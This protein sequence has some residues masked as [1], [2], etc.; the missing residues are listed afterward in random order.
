MPRPR[1]VLDVPVE[2]VAAGFHECF[3]RLCRVQV[4][5][6]AEDRR[7][8]ADRQQRRCGKPQGAADMLR[9]AEQRRNARRR[10]VFH[11]RAADERVHAHADD[12]RDD[13]LTA[14]KEQPRND[15]DCKIA[16]ASMQKPEHR[17]PVSC[18]LLLLLQFLSSLPWESKAA[19]SRRLAGRFK[20]G[21]L[22]RPQT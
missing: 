20:K 3:A 10:R 2:Q 11:G 17:A 18:L 15:A 9:P 5:Q 16:P 19:H 13:Q 6:K 21:F 14:R 22:K 12:L 4:R 7:K 8:C 1:Q